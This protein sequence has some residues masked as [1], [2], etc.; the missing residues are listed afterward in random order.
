[1]TLSTA[2]RWTPRDALASAAPVVVFWLAWMAARA[3]WHRLPWLALAAQLW[4]AYSATW[5]ALRLLPR[6]RQAS[7]RAL[8][9]AA[10]AGAGVGAALGLPLAFDFDVARLAAPAWW[11]R[12]GALPFASTLAMHLPA[13]LAR[14]R[15]AARHA[16][17]VER[18][19]QAAAVA[20]LSRQ[21]SEARLKALQAQVEP[22]FLYNTLAS[23]QYLV[24]HDPALADTLLTHLHDWLRSALPQMRTP[25]STLGREFALARSYLAIMGLRLGGRLVAD[26][27]LPAELEDVPF[28]PLMIATLVE[29]A[30]KHGAET[31]ARPVCIRVTARVDDGGLRVTVDDD[32]R[33]LFDAGPAPA[34]AGVGLANLRDRLAAMHGAAASLDV[35]AGHPHGVS[36]TI[37]LPLAA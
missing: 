20:E 27:R 36:A 24:R 34:G 5:V 4:V 16:A 9:G 26:V 33:G 25:L 21:V 14:L 23:V 2:P 30:V 11:Q 12:E 19:R 18:A 6:D 10:L 8:V 1:M 13:L 32:G 15:E 35:V 7:W 29:N 28:A 31:V 3:H 17:G 22:H 37:R